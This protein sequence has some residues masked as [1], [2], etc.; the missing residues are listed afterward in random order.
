MYL[1]GTAVLLVLFQG[2]LRYVLL[3][4]GSGLSAQVNPNEKVRSNTMGSGSSLP[5]CGR[6][7]ARG[8][9]IARRGHRDGG[10]SVGCWRHHQ[11]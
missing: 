4:S 2:T 7:G 1:Y 5:R 10:G 11:G 6:R 8:G 9:R 3:Y